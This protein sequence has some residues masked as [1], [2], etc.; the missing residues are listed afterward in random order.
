MHKKNE[1]ARSQFEK[2]SMLTF[3]PPATQIM[4]NVGGQ[5]V[6]IEIVFCVCVGVDLGNY[7]LFQIILTL[8]FKNI[9]I[10][11]SLRSFKPQLECFARTSSPS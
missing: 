11:L 10:L 2:D 1:E 9:Y 6:S 5:V 4:L 7:K 3:V 8:I